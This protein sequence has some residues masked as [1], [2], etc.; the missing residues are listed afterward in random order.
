MQTTIKKAIIIF[1][2]GLLPLFW[3]IPNTEN[4][5]KEETV[6]KNIIDNLSYKDM[7]DYCGLFLTDMNELVKNY[8][9]KYQIIQ[10]YIDY[11]N[12]G[13]LL[14]LIETLNSEEEKTFTVN[15]YLNDIFSVLD[16]NN[17]TPQEV[18]SDWD[19]KEQKEKK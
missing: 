3:F 17:I 19:G 8:P 11:Y 9:E 16:E 10:E 7:Y 12:K 2:I 4:K 5:V 18:Y 13:E 14:A 1:L 6:I 15:M